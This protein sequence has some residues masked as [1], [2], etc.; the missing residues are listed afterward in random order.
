MRPLQTAEIIA[1]GTELLTPFRSDTNSLVL[2]TRLNDLGIVL[3]GKVVAGDDVDWLAAALELALSRVDLVLTT[4]GLGPTEDDVTREA[5]G[6]ALGRRLEPN[7]AVL[8]G[9]E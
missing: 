2:T 9:I 1:V 6:R 5:V 7:D 3:A 8:A 4:G